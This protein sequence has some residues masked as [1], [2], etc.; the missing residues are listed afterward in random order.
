VGKARKK[1][2]KWSN[3]MEM[4]DRPRNNLT[5]SWVPDTAYAT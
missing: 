5:P 4:K 3:L 1:L 2:R